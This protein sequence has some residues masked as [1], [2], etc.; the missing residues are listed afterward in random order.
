M[1]LK[2]FFISFII[3]FSSRIFPAILLA[4]KLGCELRIP[5]KTWRAFNPSEAPQIIFKNELNSLAFSQP[6]AS[7]KEAA[8][9]YPLTRK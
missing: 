5:D 2:Y 3:Q 9:L 7:F 8:R 6:I 4:Q 1:I